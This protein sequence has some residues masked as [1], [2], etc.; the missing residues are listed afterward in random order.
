MSHDPDAHHTYPLF[1]ITNITTHSRQSRFIAAVR[2][3]AT[4]VRLSDPNTVPPHHTSH[5]T[6]VAPS[7]LRAIASV[8]FFT[9]MSCTE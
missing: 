4:L 7:P 2:D 5:I 1:F 8:L 9:Y 3:G 6:P